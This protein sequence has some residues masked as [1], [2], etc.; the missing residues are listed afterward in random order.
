M[1]YDENSFESEREGPH[2][3]DDR[4]NRREKKTEARA[5]RSQK[6]NGHQCTDSRMNAT[7]KYKTTVECEVEEAIFGDRRRVMTK[8]EHYWNRRDSSMKKSCLSRYPLRLV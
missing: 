6:A 4:G 1:S 8:L 7:S 5:R 2:G 3:F